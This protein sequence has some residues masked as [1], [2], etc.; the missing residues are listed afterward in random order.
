MTSKALQLAIDSAQDVFH[1]NMHHEVEVKFTAVEMK[2]LR[3]GADAIVE[4]RQP[5]GSRKS[6]WVFTLVDT[7]RAVERLEETKSPPPHKIRVFE[8]HSI[9]RAAAYAKDTVLWERIEAMIKGSPYYE[10]ANA[11][12]EA[13]NKIERAEVRLQKKQEAL[14]K[15]IEDLGKQLGEVGF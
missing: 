6:E 4:S 2:T 15:E 9:R 13:I 3:K 11:A 10:L 1:N 5:R 14:Q 12:E 8:L 7:V